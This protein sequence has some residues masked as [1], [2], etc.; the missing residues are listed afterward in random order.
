MTFLTYTVSFKTIQ[1]IGIHFSKSR[2]SIFS[3]GNH[4]PYPLSLTANLTPSW[5]LRYFFSS[6][7]SQ[8]MYFIDYLYRL[9]A[10][11]LFWRPQGKKFGRGMV[12]PP[13]RMGVKYG[14]RFLQKKNRKT[15]TCF[16]TEPAKPRNRIYFVKNG[17]IF[18]EKSLMGTLLCQ[19][20]P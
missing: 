5:Y 14:S 8:R 12:T 13:G 10:L 11:P 9:T 2:L 6:K 18:Q 19:N 17:P 16:L 1:S 4:P 15:F 20:D 7:W 3:G